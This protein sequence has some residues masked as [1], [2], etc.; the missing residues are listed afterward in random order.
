VRQI[1]DFSRKTIRQPESV[2]LASFTEETV[3]FL[4]STLPENIQIDLRIDAG[5]FAIEADPS[6]LQQVVTNL[7]VNARYAMPDGGVL[8]IR[9][10]RGKYNG[11]YRCQICEQPITGEW[12]QLQ[13]TD[14]G[15][16][17]PADILPR[18][19]EPFFTT[20]E[21][22]NGSGL[23]LPQVAGIMAQ[24]GGHTRVE[25]EVGQG[26]TFTVY[27]PPLRSDVKQ[28]APESD[29]V[30][31]GHGETILLVEDDTAVLQATTVA[32]E[33]LGYRVLT[34]STGRE[35]INL[36]DDHKTQIALVLSAMI[37]SD[38]DGEALFHRLKARNPHLKMVLI[39]GYP[40]AEKRETL[41]A[42]GIAAWILKPAS[43]EQLSQ[44]VGQALAKQ[45]GRWD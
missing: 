8:G 21:V 22:G 30:R 28:V 33:Y 19:F 25:T 40:M 6:Q 13:V 34:A 37:M 5:D 41:L 11:R 29:Q 38:I 4:A 20:R 18:I 23:G 39:S 16:G 32:L 43:F 3:Q 44:V 9:V 36:F 10:S 14:T 45:R 12:I 27:L 7:A 17:I 42:Q 35:A 2:D 1:L 15:S 31:Q 24:H 26:T